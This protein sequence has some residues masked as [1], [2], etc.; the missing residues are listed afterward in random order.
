ML[1]CFK[2]IEFTVSFWFILNSKYQ[3]NFELF[4]NKISTTVQEFIILLTID[5]TLF[6]KIFDTTTWDNSFLTKIHIK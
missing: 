1:L 5:E 4:Q 2:F 6:S 3:Y